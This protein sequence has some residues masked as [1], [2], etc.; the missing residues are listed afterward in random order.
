MEAGIGKVGKPA[1]NVEGCIMAVRRLADA[2]H[3]KTADLERRNRVMEMKIGE[4]AV[5][6]SSWLQGHRRACAVYCACS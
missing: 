5:S 4:D 3:A 6:L 1:T 2:M